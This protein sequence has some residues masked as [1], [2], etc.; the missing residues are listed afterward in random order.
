MA[1]QIQTPHPIPKPIRVFLSY[2]AKQKNLAEDVASQLRVMGIEPGNLH[3]EFAVGDNIRDEI[4]M[5]IQ[6]SAAVIALVTP[7]SL[8]S[9]WLSYELGVAYGLERQVIPLVIN[10]TADQLPEQ[11]SSR[12]MI[13]LENLDRVRDLVSQKSNK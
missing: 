1:E 13:R 4:K 5:R 6:E 10:V 9:E 7:D 12:M 8:D 3:D 2:A 11:L